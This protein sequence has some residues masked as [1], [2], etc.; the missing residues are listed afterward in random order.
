MLFPVRERH[1][2]RIAEFKKDHLTIALRPSQ[3]RLSAQER[4]RFLSTDISESL[5]LSSVCSASIS[6]VMREVF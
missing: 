6:K 4:A 1:S 3:Y 5:I 2:C